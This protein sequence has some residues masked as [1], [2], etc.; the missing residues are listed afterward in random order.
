[1]LAPKDEHESDTLEKILSVLKIAMLPSYEKTLVPG[2]DAIYDAYFG[3]P[4]EFDIEFFD[5]THMIQPQRCVL[6][7]MSVNYAAGGHGSFFKTADAAYA[8][9]RTTTGRPTTLQLA[10]SFKELRLM[11]RDQFTGSINSAGTMKIEFI[12]GG[13]DG[14]G[15]RRY[16]F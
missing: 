8:D 3:Y 5:A 11:T 16:K 4:Y 15:K 6:E 12:P 9:I 14:N 7:H 13:V 2:V 10:C 1:M